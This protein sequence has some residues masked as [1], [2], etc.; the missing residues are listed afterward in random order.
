MPF[1]EADMYQPVKKY[2]ESLG[3][4]VTAEVK[5]A[6]VTAFG[7][8]ELVILELKRNFN[9][10]L[11][12]QALDRQQTADKAYI[13]LPR[14]KKHNSRQFKHIR[15]IAA[16][17]GLGLMTVAMDSAVKT[18]EVHADPRPADGAAT[19][20]KRG[21]AV[22]RSMLLEIAG[23][24]M[25]LNTGGSAGTKQLTA[26]R[27]KCIQIACA[28]YDN[29]P[30]SAKDLID[31]RG[32]EKDARAVM[33]ANHYGWFKRLNKGVYALSDAGVEAIEHGSDFKEIIDYYRSGE[34]QT[35]K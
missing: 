33:Y 4:T 26:Y 23:R 22:K 28:L 8:G 1:T 14:P 9:V 15:H 18:V 19:P 27:E 3:Y 34:N 20:S 24:S 2:L 5:G 21:A 30:S 11:L 13:V 6:D 16:S 31:K 10:K 29:G 35:F 12:F 32:C 17:L 7:A 25:D